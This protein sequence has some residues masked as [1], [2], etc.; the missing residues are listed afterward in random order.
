[1]MPDEEEEEPCCEQCGRILDWT[2]RCVKC[3]GVDEEDV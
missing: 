3:D 2:G 1:M